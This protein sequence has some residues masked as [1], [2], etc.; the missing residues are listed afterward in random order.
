MNNYL[1]ANLA[2]GKISKGISGG[3]QAGNL[4]VFIIGEENKFN[5][6][7]LDF[8]KPAT[9]PSPALGDNFFYEPKTQVI[10][11]DI[12]IRAGTKIG[13]YIINE[14]I[15]ANSNNL[16]RTATVINVNGIS[17]T[18]KPTSVFPSGGGESEAG[19]FNLKYVHTGIA[20][21]SILGSITLSGPTPVEGSIPSAIGDLPYFYS[22][23]D[24]QRALQNFGDRTVAIYYS[25]Y[26][27]GVQTFVAGS[28][29]FSIPFSSP[30]AIR[31]L[32]ITNGIVSVNQ[33]GD[34]SYNYLY[35]NSFPFNVTSD[36]FQNF[37]S[38][39]LPSG[40]SNLNLTLNGAA[41]KYGAL[42]FNSPDWSAVIGS[43]EETTIW[44]EIVTSN[45][46]VAQGSAIL[47]KRLT[48]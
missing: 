1:Y 29:N 17:S 39:S 12:T 44:I 43:N 22:A 24:I 23:Y 47:R 20:T 46:V 7:F 41:G 16:N 14:T 28:F 37:E 18:F 48:S 36:S 45:Q 40:S 21:I 27:T 10:N 42:N 2:T 15:A 19:E 6:Y 33:T 38:T 9:Y 35:T 26:I 32:P 13:E 8:P 30:E 5:L 25:P 11:T 34:N 4:P 31:A 3:G